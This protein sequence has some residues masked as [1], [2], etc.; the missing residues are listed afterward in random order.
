MGNL[1]ELII[2]LNISFSNRTILP[3]FGEKRI[4][5]GKKCYYGQCIVCEKIEI[6]ANQL[7]EAEIEL[8]AKRNKDVKDE[9]EHEIIK[10]FNE[11]EAGST[12]SNSM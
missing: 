10:E 7:K 8:V 6:V 11:N 4:N 3:I 1:E 9:D 2:G 12:A 5:C